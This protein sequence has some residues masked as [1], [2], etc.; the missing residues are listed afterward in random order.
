MPC[1]QQR[2]T[3]FRL[4]SC[5]RCQASSEVSST[6]T[7]SSGLMPALLKSTSM[8]P[9]SST[10]V[11]YISLNRALVGDIGPERQLALGSLRE[12]DSDDACALLGE[13]PRR[14]RADPAR[15]TGDHADLAIQPTRHQPSV[16]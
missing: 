2:K 9:I 6:E 1:L 8:R 7:S 4:T 11:A 10:A 15:G 13:E 12:V 3:D 16:A 14:L 5:T